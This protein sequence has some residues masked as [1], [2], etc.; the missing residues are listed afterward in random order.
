[1]FVFV[2]FGLVAVC[3]TGY[4]QTGTVT[5]A[6]LLTGVGIGALACA[7]LVANNLRDIAGDPAVGKQHPGH[8]ARRPRAPAAFYVALVAVAAVALVVVAALTTWWALL[9][10]LRLLLLVRRRPR[11]C[12]PVPMGRALIAVLKATGIAELPRSQRGRAGLAALLR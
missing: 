7:I 3:G 1:M 5:L 4:V 10:L 11:A 8:P 12:S 9:G 2:F 6:A